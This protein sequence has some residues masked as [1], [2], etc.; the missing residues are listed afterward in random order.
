MK[1][2]T[3]LLSALAVGLG[4]IA[5]DNFVESRAAATPET[6]TLAARLT[7]DN[8][9]DSALYKLTDTVHVTLDTGSEHVAVEATRKVYFQDKKVQL[10]AILSGAT[11]R[12]VFDG[13]HG[14][15]LLWS[16]TVE[17]TA[18]KG[19][20]PV[21]VT[22][23]SVSSIGLLA[24]EISK[25]FEGNIELKSKNVVELNAKLYWTRTKDANWTPY[26][27]P[28]AAKN[29]DTVWAKDSIV[30]VIGSEVKSLTVS[31]TGEVLANTTTALKSLSVTEA[32]TP[33]AFDSAKLDY[34]ISV[35]SGTTKVSIT[36][37]TAAVDQTIKIGGADATS[38]TETQ[39]T[40]PA[41]DSTIHVVVTNPKN[42]T[43]STR[44]Y[45][46]KVKVSASP[47]SSRVLSSLRSDKGNWD[48]TLSSNKTT[49]TLTVDDTVKSLDITA[50]AK[51]AKATITA[52]L[53]ATFL[54]G[55]SLTSGTKFTVS[56]PSASNDLSIFVTNSNAP[57]QGYIIKF[58]LKSTTVTPT[59]PT[60]PKAPMVTPAVSYD[61]TSLIGIG[62]ASPLSLVGSK[63]VLSTIDIACDDGSSPRY[64]AKD[65]SAWSNGSS[66]SDLDTSRT[67]L[68]QCV[69]N[70]NSNKVSAQLTRTFMLLLPPTIAPVTEF[71]DTLVAHLKARGDASQFVQYCI[72]G[73]SSCSEYSDN[74]WQNLK[75][76]NDFDTLFEGDAP[77]IKVTTA[78]YARALQRIKGTQTFVKS[79]RSG[80]TF[81]KVEGNQLA[82]KGS[83][84]FTTKSTDTAVIRRLYLAQPFT[85]KNGTTNVVST[86]VTGL[87]LETTWATA[88]TKRQA[89]S[90]LFV[91][92]D[93]ASKNWSFENVDSV[94]FS[95][96]LDDLK[97]SLRF[98]PA[99]ALYD[100]KDAANGYKLTKELP[101][102]LSFK[103][104]TVA[105]VDLAYD[106]SWMAPTSPIDP[107]KLMTSI[108]G[109]AFEVVPA[110]ESDS[111]I[112]SFS[113]VTMTIKDITLIS[114]SGAVTPPT[115]AAQ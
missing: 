112:S 32:E 78:L 22:P 80:V 71:R 99:S 77:T 64:K 91:A 84:H 20:N 17:G 81:L 63:Y 35:P 107:A 51:S 23:S 15:L 88:F 46:I 25:D 61:S 39:V 1:T 92:L 21:Q 7:A 97:T 85:D 55:S 86:D 83:L 103:E 44:S 75:S 47:D 74:G 29:P 65:A 111:K 105:F 41:S 66:I 101:S 69:D 106:D 2:R 26:D 3:L 10:P 58:V 104:V 57:T 114:K 45:T 14:S 59:T 67:F 87:S 109:F 113:P 50:I 38:G 8:A 68:F 12:I 93:P 60:V 6:A 24:P 49:Y 52:K 108:S 40:I 33:I 72:G 79:P 73:A 36:A 56:T 31:A 90:N 30:G 89:Y 9:K 16:D 5:C 37:D 70:T 115:A 62:G 48:A 13:Y 27:A 98:T 43:D 19:V 95:Y 28:F 4:L 96:M 102:S 110:F 76:S 53:G 34:A 54:T 82:S 18:R 42:V 11:Y 100:V 94:R